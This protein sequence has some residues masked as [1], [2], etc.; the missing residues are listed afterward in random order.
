MTWEHPMVLNLIDL[1]V[2]HEHGNTALSIAK[3]PK[4][5]PGSVLL[6]C[7]FVIE[8]TAPK[9]LQI[10]RHLPPALIRVVMDA[11]CS[12]ITAQFDFD[13]LQGT[14]IQLNKKI[15]TQ[16]VH[17]HQERLKHMFAQAEIIATDDCRQ[18][19]QVKITEMTTEFDHEI[20][21][22]TALQKD[23]PNI[24]LDEISSLEAQKNNLDTYMHKAYARLDSSR[25]VVAG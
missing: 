3:L 12:D 22:L 9:N 5:K 2:S 20:Q 17:N 24:R 13:A 7:I 1:F 8:C 18:Q 6:E 14:A 10:N 23:N 11:N 19:S 15:I 25:L 21:R 4:V 16:L